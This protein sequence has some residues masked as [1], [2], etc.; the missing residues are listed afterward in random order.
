LKENANSRATDG[1]WKL[2]PEKFMKVVKK[3]LSTASEDDLAA[4]KEVSC[5][6]K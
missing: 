3:V 6:E 5:W 1:E 4:L 2:T